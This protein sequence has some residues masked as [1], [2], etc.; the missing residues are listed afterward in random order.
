LARLTFADVVK[1]YPDGTRA[2]ESLTLE[3]ADGE[4]VVLVGPSGC[5][6][7]TA[8]RMVA[9]LEEV[10]S[11]E[12]LIDDRVINLVEPR[13]RDVAMVFQNYALYPNMTVAENIG[14]PLR[15]GRVR[16]R[17]RDERVL[18]V[19]R[20][21]GLEEHLGRKPRHLSGGQRQR[22]AMGRAII[23]QPRVFLMD[24]PLSNLDA[25]LRVQMRAEISKIQ[26]R[27]GVTTLY[28]THDQVEAM[29]VGDRVAVMRGGV[30]QQYATPEQVYSRPANLFVASFVGSPP[31]NL[32]EG[33]L[34][35]RG[36]RL[37]VAIG[38]RSIAVLDSEVAGHPSLA[39]R[40]GRRVVVG[41]R[42]E[43][44]SARVAESPDD[45]TIGGTVV[46]REA[47]GSDVLVHFHLPQE[48]PVMS[49]ETRRL[50]H[51]TNDPTEIED[52]DRRTTFIARLEP[53]ASAT[54][55]EPIDLWLADPSLSFFD[56]ETGHALT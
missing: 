2:V 26:R 32:V 10:T 50:A 39:G 16:R 17:E 19:A 21:L 14:F 52:L 22:V 43:R 53:G 51:D 48:V 31:M 40:L 49:G 41:V 24:E 47:L 30:L 28:V 35:E 1:V 4:L 29:T 33:I 55:G 46:V 9:G 45:R 44:I 18:A 34:S 7:T 13:T 12:I 6:K 15:V 25:K 3:A 11:G 37:Y 42:P 23:R 20:T 36:G 8:L 5:G 38:S 54:E 56:Q 27:L